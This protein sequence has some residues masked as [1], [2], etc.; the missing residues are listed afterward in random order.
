[1]CPQTIHRVPSPFFEN[2]AP[3]ME[4]SPGQSTPPARHLAGPGRKIQI[5]DDLLS[6]TRQPQ[7]PEQLPEARHQSRL[8]GSYTAPVDRL[9]SARSSGH[10]SA[11]SRRLQACRRPSPAGMRTPGFEGLYGGRE[12]N[13]DQTL[14]DEASEAR[15]EDLESPRSGRAA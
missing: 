1:M 12:N 5:Y 10:T 3:R 15:E 7:T 14:F 11:T 6:P 13:D 9:R 4:T 2:P 8:L